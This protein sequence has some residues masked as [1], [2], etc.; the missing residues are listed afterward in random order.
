MSKIVKGY[1][2]IIDLDLTNVPNHLHQV[3]ID[4]HIEDIKIYKEEQSNLPVKLRY[5]NTVIRAQK[6]RELEDFH[7]KKRKEEKL[8]KQKEEDKIR[9]ETFNRIKEIKIR[10][11]QSS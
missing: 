5:E 6:I 7:L 11:S 3:M 10:N 8:K 9:L 4:Q 1:K 2:G